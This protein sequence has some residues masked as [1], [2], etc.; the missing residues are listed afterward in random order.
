DVGGSR[1]DGRR[2]EEIDR[3]IRPEIALDY[4]RRG[5]HVEVIVLEV[6]ALRPGRLAARAVAVVPPHLG[7]GFRPPRPAGDERLFQDA[8]L[9]VELQEPVVGYFLVD[10]LM[11]ER[12]GVAGGVGAQEFDERTVVLVTLPNRLTGR[13]VSLVAT[14]GLP[15]GQL[16]AKVAVG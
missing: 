3:L 13:L 10:D 1:R 9:E 12:L 2:I 8:E 4:L 11:N 15:I 6:V 7:R 16:L 14:P 5:R